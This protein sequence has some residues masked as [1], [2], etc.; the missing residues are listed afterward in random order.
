MS[1]HF[2]ETKSIMLTILCC[3]EGSVCLI[4]VVKKRCRQQQAISGIRRSRRRVHHGKRC[5]LGLLPLVRYDFSDDEVQD[6]G[7][8]PTQLLHC[9]T[10]IPGFAHCPPPPDWPR[11]DR[12]L[13]ACGVGFTGN[14]V[15]SVNYQLG[16]YLKAKFKSYC[17][18][19]S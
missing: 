1:L 5:E 12:S 10:N 2:T 13:P 19:R 3:A 7:R 6:D 9:R 4:R 15:I 11:S 17:I 18:F 14:V 16:F 8:P